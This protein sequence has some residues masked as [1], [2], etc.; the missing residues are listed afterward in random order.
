[1]VSKLARRSRYLQR[2]AV[3]QFR[4]G[5]NLSREACVEDEGGNLFG[6]RVQAR[7]KLAT[8]RQHVVTSLEI[9]NSVRRTK[10]QQEL[11]SD[12]KEALH[13]IVFRG[14]VLK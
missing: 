9:V 3:N 1:M 7:E 2:R 8:A 10:G 11:E 4:E 14:K 5:L 12:V 13:D 6:K